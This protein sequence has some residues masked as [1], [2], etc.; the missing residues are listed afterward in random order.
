MRGGRKGKNSSV[1]ELRRLREVMT[2]G[3]DCSDAATVK[4]RPQAKRCAIEAAIL[5]WKNRP[6]F[7]SISLAEDFARS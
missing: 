3:V 4:I 1:K 2:R 5:T 6:E 7:R